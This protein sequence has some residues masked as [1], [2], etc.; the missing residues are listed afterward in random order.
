[1]TDSD[2][3]WKEML[4]QEL[5]LAEVRFPQEV[6]ALMPAVR[7]S[8][9]MAELDHLLRFAKTASLEEVRSALAQRPA[10]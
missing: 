1:M 9:L 6:Q 7:Q 8:T 10:S 4:E 2:S 5:P 3:P